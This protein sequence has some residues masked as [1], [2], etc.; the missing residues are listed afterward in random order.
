MAPMPQEEYDLMNEFWQLLRENIGEF[1]RSSAERRTTQ[2]SRSL[3]A[4]GDKIGISIGATEIWLYIRSGVE[5]KERPPERTQ[6]MEEYSRLIRERLDDQQ[7]LRDK[8][9]ERDG[10]SIGVQRLWAR[11]DKTQWPQV[12]Q[13]VKEQFDELRSIINEKE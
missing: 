6:Q 5:D 10:Q 8:K 2:W 3:N 7:S 13:W 9:K 1:Q 11:D 4:H 12:A